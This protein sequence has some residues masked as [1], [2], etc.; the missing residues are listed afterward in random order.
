MFEF[1]NTFIIRLAFLDG[2]RGL[3]IAVSNAHVTFTKYLKLYEINIGYS[4]YE[5]NIVS[6]EKLP[7][8][9]QFP[10]FQFAL[11]ENRSPLK[12]VEVIKDKLIA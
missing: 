8:L 3:L 7:V 4:G 6:I 5:K 10:D 2:Y 9:S 11:G 12:D 1:I